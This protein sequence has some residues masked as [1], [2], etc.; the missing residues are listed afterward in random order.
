MIITDIATKLQEILNDRTNALNPT[1][2]HF[3]VKSQGFALDKISNKDTGVNTIPVFVSVISGENNPVPNLKQKNRTYEINIYFPIRFKETFFA[4]EDYLDECFVAKKVIF[5]SDTALCNTS[6]A[7]YGEITGIQAEQF[8]TWVNDTYEGAVRVFKQEEDINEPYMSMTLRLYTTT[9]G[10]GFMF[11]NDV[12]YNLSFKAKPILPSKIKFGSVPS[13]EA[14]RDPSNDRNGKYAWHSENYLSNTIYTNNYTESGLNNATV[15]AYSALISDFVNTNQKVKQ[16]L[17]YDE[18]GDTITYNEDLV[19]DSSGTGASVS[20]ISEQLVGV[21]KYVKNTSNITN[22]NKSIVAYV[23]DTDF[24]KHIL[25]D[26]NIQDL[27]KITDL[28]L[29]KT[30]KIGSTEIKYEFSQLILSVNENIA[31]GE[32]LSFTITFGD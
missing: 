15:Y 16:I 32:P 6:P 14:T 22:F 17:E 4:L 8:E 10:K 27:D 29:T 21:D 9:I 11:G 20:P 5:G 13:Y 1:D 26:Y 25:R 12:K 2:F 24:W 23:K 30:Y 28:K 19:W 3:V 31:L 18:I 7:E